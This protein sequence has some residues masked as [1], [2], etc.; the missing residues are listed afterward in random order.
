[1][2][3]V[4]KIK[5]ETIHAI[6]AIIYFMITFNLVNL[7]ERLMLRTIDPG[8]GSYLLATTGALLAGKLLIIVN[9]FSF[10]NAF[11]NKPMI[12][13]IVWKFFIYGLGTLIVRI[14]DEV[15]HFIFKYDGVLLILQQLWLRLSA[16]LFWA[17]EIWILMLFIVYIVAQE[18][19]RVIGKD[20]MMMMVFGRSS[21]I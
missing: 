21:F 17:V 6:P 20:K 10:I 12:Y 2:P 1:M 15:A 9:A 16:S 3:L 18:F 8:F 13:N 7:T 11:P 5:E 19:N 4:E 14:I